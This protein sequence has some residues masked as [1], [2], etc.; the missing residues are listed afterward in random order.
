METKHKNEME[1]LNKALEDKLPIFD[2]KPGVDLNLKRWDYGGVFKRA[3]PVL[4]CGLETDS[5]KMEKRVEL[6][7]D[8][9]SQKLKAV[10]TKLE[11]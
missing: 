7:K 3:E 2:G 8:F 11:L 4:N 10:D 9:K 1:R 5:K 6:L